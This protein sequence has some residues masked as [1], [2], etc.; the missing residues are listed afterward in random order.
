MKEHEEQR[1]QESS[2]GGGGASDAYEVVCSVRRLTPLETGRLQGFPDGYSAIDGENT[3]DASQY[4]ADGNSW[5]TPCANFI[6]SRTEMEL[7]RLGHKGA[8]NYATCCSGIEAHSVS[9][10]K[11]GWKSLFFSEIEPFP[12]RVLAHHYP[13]TPNLGDMTQIHF[14]EKNGVVS[15]AHAEGEEYDLPSCFKQAEIREIPFKHGDLQVFSGGT[16]C[17]TKGAMVLTKQGYVPIEEIK[18]GDEV[19]THRGR[20]CKVLRVGSKTSCDLVRADFAGRDAIVCT[21]DHPFPMLSVASLAGEVASADDAVLTKAADGAG[22]YAMKVA[23]WKGKC[24][25]PEVP[26]IPKFQSKAVP[27]K[28]F[29][30][31]CGWYATTGGIEETDEFGEQVVFRM[32]GKGL[33]AFEYAFMGELEYLVEEDEI[34]NRVII[35]DRRLAEFLKSEFGHDMSDKKIPVWAYRDEV[36]DA[37][38]NGAWH[39]TSGFDARIVSFKSPSVAYG[40]CDLSDGNVIVY[41]NGFEC[42]VGRELDKEEGDCGGYAML[43]ESMRLPGQ[44]DTV[45][46]IEVDED[47]TY[48]VNGIVTHNCQDISVAGKRAGMAENSGSRSSLAFH[49]QRIIDETKPAFTLWENVCFGGDTLVTTERGYKKISEIEKGELVRSIDGKCHKVVKVMKTDNKQTVK[50]TAM[51]AAALTVTPNHPFYARLN[52]HNKKNPLK[53]EFCKPEWTAAGNLTMNHYIGYKVDPEGTDRIGL[54]NAYAVGRWLADGSVAIRSSKTQ[55]GSKGGQKARIF[56]STGLKKRAKLAKELSRLPYHID[57]SAISDY[58]VNFTFTSE[59]FYDLIKDCGKGA[60]NKKVPQ[61]AYSLI[62]EEQAEMLRGYLDGDGHSRRSNEMTYRSSSRALAM[63]VARLVRNVY[64]RGVSVRVEKGQGKIE[65]CGRQVNAHDS[66]SCSFVPDKIDENG[67]T[68]LIS[69]YEDGFVWCPIKKIEEGP[70]Q[71]VYNLTVADTHTYEANGIVVH[72]CG[73]FSSNGGADFI[74]F[75]NKCAESGYSMAWRVLDAQYTTTEEFPRAVPQRRRRIWLVGYKGNDWRVPA[76]IVF[77]RQKDLT[78]TPPTRVPG[79]GF[80][81]IFDGV[82]VDSIRKAHSAETKTKTAEAD[83]FDL[84]AGLEPDNC[85]P[86]KKVSQMIQL[87]QFP[88]GGDF[89][90]VRMCDVFSFAKLLGEPLY[91]GDVFRSDKK[92][93]EQAFRETPEYRE[94]ESASEED[95]K[96]WLSGEEAADI[97]ARLESEENDGKLEWQGAEKIEKKILENIGNAGILANGR[98]LTMKCNVWTSG[99][100]LSPDTYM[101]WERLSAAG[102]TEAADG[103]LPPAYDGTVCGLSDILE[104]N[105]DDK[106]RL[107][108]RACFGIL[109]RAEKRGKVL[110]EPLYCALVST[111]RSNAGLVKYIALYGADK[112]KTDKDLSERECARLCFDKYISTVLKFDDVVP[113]SPKKTAGESEDISDFDEGDSVDEDGN[114]LPKDCGDEAPNESTPVKRET[115][116]AKECCNESGGECSPAIMASQ[117]KGP[118]TSQDGSIV[119]QFA[120]AN[121]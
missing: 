3:S 95:L 27:E 108:W 22:K 51:G 42:A 31:L 88:G 98:I 50:L 86:V 28:S 106:Y 84:F 30:S 67:K 77:E 37:F 76:R 23:P 96:T 54:E 10:R 104:D 33:H 97:L 16:P 49:F 29:F 2:P 81:S 9:V 36:R 112:R 56:I 66:W 14:D 40:L 4:K 71:D 119:A 64:H 101:K 113:V 43:C 63:G 55:N 35:R 107:T 118:G 53:R 72:N 90:K 19:L 34:G 100:Q 93:A 117:F 115:G 78:D 57:E 109:R 41:R 8:V 46:N 24:E 48:V 65:I 85:E 32:N 61:Y 80:Q 21:A 6:S 20:F 1:I 83:G 79:I 111:I 75:V 17:F 102:D 73:A 45:Y 121:E 52:L 13:Q 87:D 58:A 89:S 69:F 70:T 5:A 120:K 82:D 114:P 105:P 62:K 94:H 68:H 25:L 7:R 26:E 99:I 91:V 44:T 60:R 18:V 12:C 39:Y 15:N 103:V 38:A 110:P 59:D 74:W 92:T 116:K 47:H 11:L